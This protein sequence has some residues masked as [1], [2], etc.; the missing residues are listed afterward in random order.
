MVQALNLPKF[1]NGIVK[2]T[3]D[4]LS[5]VIVKSQ[6]P[7]SALCELWKGNKSYKAWGLTFITVYKLR[8]NIEEIV[9]N[10]AQAVVY[11]GILI[12]RADQLHIRL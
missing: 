10:D 2:S 6:T 12:G 5:W 9:Y 1:I 11:A 3:A 7:K 8:L 4:L